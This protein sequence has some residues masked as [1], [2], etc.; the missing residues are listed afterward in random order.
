VLEWIK[1]HETGER[2][3]LE[4]PE[5]EWL[6]QRDESWRIVSEALWADVRDRIAQR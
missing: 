3:R 1:D 4:R 2:R 5:S 6:R